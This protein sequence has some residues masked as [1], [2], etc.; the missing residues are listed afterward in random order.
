MHTEGISSPILEKEL[1]NFNWRI[2]LN[3]EQFEF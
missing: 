3:Y 2:I 1:K